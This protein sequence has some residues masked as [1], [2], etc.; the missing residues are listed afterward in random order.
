MHNLFVVVKIIKY[1]DVFTMC[2]ISVVITF[3][4]TQI[5]LLDK[6]IYVQIYLPSILK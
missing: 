4:E 5:A 1:L 3:K 6:K 2:Y